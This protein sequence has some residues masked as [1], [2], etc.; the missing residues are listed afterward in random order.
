[1]MKP[2]PKPEPQVEF[3]LLDVPDRESGIRVA[4]RTDA[5]GFRR[6]LQELGDA[7][8]MESADWYAQAVGTGLV[9]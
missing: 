6:Y 9:A 7:W 8:T 5:R 3:A 4:I 1:M 2:K